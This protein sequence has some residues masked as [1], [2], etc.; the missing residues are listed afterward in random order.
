MNYN[1]TTKNLLS[2]LKDGQD[3][4]RQTIENIM[5]PDKIILDTRVKLS[6]RKLERWRR[7]SQSIS[8]NSVRHLPRKRS[9]T[10][11]LTPEYEVRK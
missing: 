7:D 11:Q 8:I 5:P 2:K 10:R 1:S 4:L 6:E 3:A 9:R